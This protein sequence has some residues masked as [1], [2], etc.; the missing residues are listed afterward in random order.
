MKKGLEDQGYET[1]EFT[2]AEQNKIPEDCTSIMMLSPAKAL[3]PNEAQLINAFLDNG[4]RA[5][6][7][8]E[9]TIS[10]IDQ[11]K[12]LRELLKTWGIDVKNGLIVDLRS[13]MEGGDASIP[14]NKQYN[15]GHAI[16]KDFRVPSYFPFARPLDVTNPLPEGIKAEWLSKSSAESWG[17]EDMASIAK[18]QVQYNEGVDIKGPITTA[19][20]ASG[21]KKDSK[22]T[23]ETRIVVFGSA[24]F[25][26]NQYSRFGG[27]LDYILNAISWTLEDE[28]LISIRV[29]EDAEAKLEMTPI[30]I[31][32]IFW[33]SVIL[34]PLLISIIGII[35]WVRRKKL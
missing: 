29:K 18:G 20:A 21:K 3:F 35:I 10:Q 33:V 13:R 28:S 9:A 15:T 17:E 11:T 24:Q 4:G 23:R 6:I 2:L 7:A 8:L 30:Q 5:V 32:L 27:N 16:T 34:V 14:I 12:E 31:T 26:N 19:V 1:K 22:A 25:A